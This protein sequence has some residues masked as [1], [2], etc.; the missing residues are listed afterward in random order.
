V[1]LTAAA[2]EAA[3]H[4]VF[5]AVGAEKAGPVARALSGRAS[6][7]TP[8]S[9]IRSRKRTTALVDRAAAAWL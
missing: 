6:T 2:L 9:L 8:A 4:V 1:T 5:L 7:E 3:S